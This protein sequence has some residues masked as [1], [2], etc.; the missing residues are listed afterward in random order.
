MLHASRLMNHDPL[1]QPVPS[2]ASNDNSTQQF[3]L[4]S[5]SQLSSSASLPPASASCARTTS[6]AVSTAHHPPSTFATTNPTTTAPTSAPATAALMT[7]ATQNSFQPSLFA[8][9][10]SSQVTAHPAKHA[11]AP[12][13]TAGASFD[14]R[15]VTLYV[16]GL[17]ASFDQTNLQYMFMAFNNRLVSYKLLNDFEGS[18]AKPTR[19]VLVQAK[20]YEAA[21]DLIETFH[22][23]NGLTVEIAENP[24]QSSRPSSDGP[25]PTTSPATIASQASRFDAFSPVEP[26]PLTNGSA[27]RNGN[28]NGH[29]FNHQSPYSSQSPIGNHLNNQP[30]VSGKSLINDGNDDDDITREILSLPREYQADNGS[31]MSTRG[32]NDYYYTTNGH[33]SYAENGMASTQRRATAPQLPLSTPMAS[34][35]LNTGNNGMSAAQHGTMGMYPQS[36]HSS[37]MSTTNMAGSM[38]YHHHSKY[39]P[40]PKDRIPPPSNPA[41]QNPPCNTL[42]VGNLPMDAQEEELRRV[43]ANARGYKR[44]C[45]RTKPNGTMCFV[46]FEDTATASRAM[47][48]MFGLLLSNSKR[49]GM[50]L[51]FSK[52]PLGVRA[53]QAG[54]PGAGSMSGHHGMMGHG[55]AGFSAATGPPPGLHPYPPPPPGL[56]ANRSA[57]SYAAGPSMPNGTAT[58]G[59]GMGTTNGSNLT[60]GISYAAQSVNGN[61]NNAL[62]IGLGNGTSF[63]QRSEQR[64]NPWPSSYNPSRMPSAYASPYNTPYTTPPVGSNKAGGSNGFG[65]FGRGPRQASS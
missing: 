2:G 36:A 49:G 16:R 43:F 50:R 41:D 37:T 4:P 5:R 14:M 34:L 39:P 33:A 31:Y 46:E 52:N 45:Y 65:S 9:M 40:L 48:D 27:L 15:P 38:G 25:S 12:P 61:G 1:N 11:D 17:E 47:N 32:Q 23:K 55:A 28:G 30:R 60:N 18:P 8:A 44:M 24:V 63:E 53:S 42:Y 3:Q 19:A 20:T 22:K 64:G 10:A 7:T 51:S 54:G 35:S 21:R 62:G 26:T 29:A 56:G 59:S 58:N 13:V 6:N 57:S